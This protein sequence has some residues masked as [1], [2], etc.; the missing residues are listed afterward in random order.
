MRCR[1]KNTVKSVKTFRKIQLKLLLFICIKNNGF[2]KEQFVVKSKQLL[3]KL[4]IE[5]GF[6]KEQFVVKSK[7]VAVLAAVG[8][9]FKKE[10]FVVKSKQ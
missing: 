1:A 5:V 6:K 9:C 7:L 10:Q 8:V 3:R 2:K 4:N